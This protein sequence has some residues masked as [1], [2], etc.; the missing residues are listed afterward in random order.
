MMALHLLAALLA[1]MEI[2]KVTLGVTLKYVPGNTCPTST[3][4]CH[5]SMAPTASL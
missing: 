3:G 5:H 2:G 4:C 1:G